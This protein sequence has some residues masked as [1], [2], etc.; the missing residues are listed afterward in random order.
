MS[1]FWNGTAGLVTGAA[2]GIGLELSK[3]LVARGARV[4]MADVDAGRLAAAVSGVGD[5]AS[6]VVLDVR[7]AAAVRRAVDAVVARAGRIDFL[8]NNAGIGICG[9]AHELDVAHYDRVLD[10]NVRGVVHG[11]AAAYPVMMRQRGGCIVNTASLAGLA[12][13]PL[14]G[15][16]A[17]SKHAVV[18]LTRSLRA[19]A[20]RHGVRV[21]ALCPAA[22]ETP[23]LDADNP[24]DLPKVPWR[25]DV[26]RY[27]ERLAGPPASAERFAAAALRGVEQGRELVVYPARARLVAWLQRFAPGLVRVAGAKALRDELA[28]RRDAETP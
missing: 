2:S 16:Y 22:V 11:V 12:P 19:E 21:T 20:A 6:P 3:A 15:P 18:G 25:A 17:M 26:R 27:L 7:D 10:I 4:W 13:A 24:E 1:G 8:F 5:A 14:L 23:I 28:L 9:E